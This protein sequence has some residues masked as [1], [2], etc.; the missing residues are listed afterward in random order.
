MPRPAA[1]GGELDRLLG[2]G[3]RSS[4]GPWTITSSSARWLSA[5]TATKS[6]RCSAGERDRLAQLLARRD[7][8][9][10]PQSAVSPSIACTSA[11][12]RRRRG[13]R[14]AGRPRP[15]ARRRRCSAA[16]EVALQPR[17]RPGW[18]A[19]SSPGSGGGAARAGRPRPA[20]RARGAARPRR[21]RRRRAPR[22]RARRRA[23]RRCSSRSARQLAQ[24]AR[25]RRRRRR[26]RRGRTSARRRPR[27]PGPT[28][29]PATACSSASTHGAAL[30]VPA[31]GARVQ[32]RGSFARQ[33]ALGARAQQLG[34]Q[35]VV[36]EPLAVAVD[37]EHE[38]VGAL[39]RR[40]A[41][42]RRCRRR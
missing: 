36:A 39:E 27:P 6:S 8:A 1:L 21:C 10:A 38:P 29:A 37:A 28:P 17:R 14:R 33:L 13:R 32:R 9:G 40:R 2:R 34:E 4:A 11:S 15:A 31:G 20:R 41:C 24:R 19:P 7:R 23:R 42:P 35:A 25:A 18:R 26:A 5:E 12:R 16:L 3:R 30:G 22:R